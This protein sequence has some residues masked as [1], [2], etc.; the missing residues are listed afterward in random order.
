[1]EGNKQQIEFLKKEIQAW[2]KREETFPKRYK[3][4]DDVYRKYVDKYGDEKL[5]KATNYEDGLA[6][7]LASNKEAY[8]NFSQLDM[9]PKPV[10]NIEYY[11]F[12][13]DKKIKH[14]VNRLTEDE[15]LKWIEKLGK[16]GCNLVGECRSSW[17]NIE[18]ISWEIIKENMEFRRINL[19]YKD[20]DFSTPENQMDYK[21]KKAWGEY[22]ELADKL[23]YPKM[24]P[25]KAEKIV[26]NN[27]VQTNSP[28]DPLDF[29]SIQAWGKN[30]SEVLEQILQQNKK[31]YTGMHQSAYDIFSIYEPKS[32]FNLINNLLIKNWGNYPDM[33]HEFDFIAIS[34]AQDDFAKDIKSGRIIDPEVDLLGFGHKEK[35]TQEWLKIQE[36][37]SKKDVPTFKMKM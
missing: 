20:Y 21:T 29:D 28:S 18:N 17:E 6:I 7:F 36:E 26:Y 23:T 13:Q 24:D 16:T 12:G 37:K 8:Y 25:Q 5:T 22:L 30:S 34:R 11:L 35:L 27:W 32:N 10:A 1:M 9:A 33:H 3:F 2:Q 31:I 4:I 14:Q 15:R 19:L